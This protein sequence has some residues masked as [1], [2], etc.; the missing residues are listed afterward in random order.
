MCVY[1]SAPD[2]LVFVGER[3]VGDTL[4]YSVAVS[5]DEESSQH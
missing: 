4:T 3:V 2:E 1:M 5:K